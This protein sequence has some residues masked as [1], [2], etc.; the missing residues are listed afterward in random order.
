MLSE[1]LLPSC[2]SRAQLKALL[3]IAHVLVALRR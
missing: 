2:P 3:N 1:G